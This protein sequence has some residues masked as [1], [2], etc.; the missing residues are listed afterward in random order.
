MSSTVSIVKQNYDLIHFTK[1][2]GLNKKTSTD[3]HKSVQQPINQS[4]S[5]YGGS[6]FEL[7]DYRILRK[8]N[9]LDP[10]GLKLHLQATKNIYKESDKLYI[11]VFNEK[12]IIDHFLG[13]ANKYGWLR[14]EFAV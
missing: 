5:S 9:Y 1:L 11:S 3:N 6:N 8:I 10:Q 13:I 14:L 12:Y 2:N 7:Y 4:T